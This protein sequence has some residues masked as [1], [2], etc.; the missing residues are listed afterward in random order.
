MSTH[1][2]MVG[3]LKSYIKD[4]EEKLKDALDE[5]ER[6][7]LAIDSLLL[8]SLKAMKESKH[9]VITPNARITNLEIEMKQVQREV[10]ALLRV[11][12]DILDQSIEH[13][14]ELDNLMRRYGTK[15]T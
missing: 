15:D 7:R 14:T 4:L 5:S 9:T 11:Q 6:R 13:S 3:K 12:T 2:F 1:K 10:K 8:D